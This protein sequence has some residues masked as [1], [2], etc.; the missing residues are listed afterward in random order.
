MRHNS[1]TSPSSLV[2]LEAQS[3]MQD[4]RYFYLYIFHLVNYAINNPINF[5]HK[6][7]QNTNITLEVRT[8]QLKT[9]TKNL[10][11]NGSKSPNNH[12]VISTQV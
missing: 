10:P 3:I 1:K 12:I 7:D 2:K 11:I 4:I 9:K 5:Q 8:N 6:V